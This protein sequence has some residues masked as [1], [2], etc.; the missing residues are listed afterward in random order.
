MAESGETRAERTPASPVDDF[1]AFYTE[2]FPR[3]VA[4]ARVLTGD[5]AVG[6]ELAQEAM[7]RAHRHWE[8]VRGYDRPA[9]WVRR[10]TTNLASSARRRRHAERAAVERFG[11]LRSVPQLAPEVD[12]FWSVVRNLPARQRDAVMLFYLEDRSVADIAVELDCAEN[13]VKA[14]LHKARQRLARE[15]RVDP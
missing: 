8:R 9:A 13:T 3:M 11:A 14:H 15:L 6:E 1:D 2:Q 4:W 5:L 10:V 7:L 12:E